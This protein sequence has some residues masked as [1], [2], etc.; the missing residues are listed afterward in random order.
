MAALLTDKLTELATRIRTTNTDDW[1]QYWNEDPQGRPVKPKHE[2][3]CRDALLS[4]LRGLLP[5]GVVAEPEGEYANDMRADIR[6]A[7][8]DFNVPVEVKKDRNRQLWSSLNNQL[9]AKYASD[10]AT[11]GHGIYLVFWFG[12]EGMPAPPQ[13]RPPA[14]AVELRDLLEAQLAPSDKHRISICVVDVSPVK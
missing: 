3:H 7:F 8:G 13:G 11:G 1:L 5:D 2:E 10:P 12:G 6:V 4:D 14:D 9:I